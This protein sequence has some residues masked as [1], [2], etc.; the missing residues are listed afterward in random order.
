MVVFVIL[1]HFKQNSAVLRNLYGAVERS[2]MHFFQTVKEQD[3]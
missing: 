1:K 2:V 3:I